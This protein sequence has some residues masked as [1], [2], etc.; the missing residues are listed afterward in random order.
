M[1]CYTLHFTRPVSYLNIKDEVLFLAQ[2]FFGR[3]L[4]FWICA[5]SSRVKRRRE[6]A[7]WKEGNLTIGGNEQKTE[8]L[9]TTKSYIS[10]METGL[11]VLLDEYGMRIVLL[12]PEKK[13][14]DGFI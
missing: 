14:T 10:E 1:T 9:E 3:D 13:Y 8:S 2:R 6:T 4:P 12:Q 7:E 5:S 11:K